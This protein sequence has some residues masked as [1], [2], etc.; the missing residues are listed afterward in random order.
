MW[1]CGTCEIEC[2]LQH[3]C[4]NLCANVYPQLKIYKKKNYVF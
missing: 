2:C 4:T 1:C 3:S